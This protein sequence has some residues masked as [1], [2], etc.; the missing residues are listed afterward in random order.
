VAFGSSGV[1]GTN[2]TPQ[3]LNNCVFGNADF[4]YYGIPDPTGKNGNLSVDPLLVAT[5]DFHLGTSSPCI[6]A[7][8][9]FSAHP[10]WL[11]LDGEPRMMGAHVDIGADEA[12]QPGVW[13][14][15]ATSADLIQLS[16]TNAG[17][18]AYGAFE[19]TLPDSCYRLLSVG[20]LVR[21]GTDF[22]RDF[23]ILSQTGGI[24]LPMA[25]FL[26]TNFLLGRLLPGD[27]SF[28]SLSWGEPAERTS[29]TWVQ[30]GSTLVTPAVPS[31]GQMRFT[32]LG[33]PDVRYVVEASMNLTNWSGLAT[34]LGGSFDFE[35]AE[36]TNWPQRFYRVLIGP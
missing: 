20:P 30:E 17:G 9:D 12:T 23:R 6:D 29:F 19:V 31:S 18:I 26:R 8:D 3:F 2:G 5:N 34:N 33:V 10:D 22:S 36:A 4:N 16:V 1:R 7:G 21:A 35:D 32:A 14:R 15:P 11:D 27:Y 25:T 13:Q 24:C 28:T